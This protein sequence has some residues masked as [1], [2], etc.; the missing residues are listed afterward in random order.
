[1]AVTVDRVV[2]ELEA[3]LGRYEANVSRA[4]AKFDKAMSGIQKS[5]GATERIVSRAAVA[6][7]AA[8]A[9][10]SVIALARGF[11]A[12]ADEAKK[13]DAQLKLATA[14]FGT[15]AQA[16][17]DVQ[18]IADETRSGL[19]DTAGVY[20]NLVRVSKEMGATQ[21]DASRATE[22]IT[23]TF[24][25]SGA[26]AVET[27]QSL[28]QLTQGLQSGTLRGDEFNSV[29]ESA[30]RFARLLAD[31]LG[32]PIG[33]LRK[34]AEE[35]ELT[36]DKL[37]RALTDKKFTD[38]IDA[39]FRQ[40]PITF[41]EAVTRIQNSAITVFGAFDRGGE[42]STMLANFVSGGADGFTDLTDSAEQ[43]G[44][45]IRSTFAGLSDAFQPLLEGALSAF[46]SIE[47]EA[48]SVRQT[49][50]DILGG[51]DDVVN[52]LPRIQNAANSFD[53]RVFGTQFQADAQL[54]NMSGNF[55]KGFDSTQRRLQ[56]NATD[57]RM[58]A[59]LGGFDALGN[60]VAGTP[61]AGRGTSRVSPSDEKKKKTPKSKLNPDA[62][63]REEA[64][65]NDE[66]LHLK[67]DEITNATDR[68]A[69][70][71]QRIA[72]NRAAA[73]T[74]I[75]ND[76]R[77]TAA[78]KAKA[79]ALTETVA[80]LQQAK[81]I[82]ERDVQIAKDA[83]SIRLGGIRNDED[84]LRA[85]A[86]LTDSRTERR[87]IELRLLDLAYQQER[88]ELEAVVASK[89]AT[90]AQKKIAEARLAMLGRVQNTQAA[91]IDRQFESPLDSYARGLRE[92]DTNDRIESYVV[93]EL[94]AVQDGIASA[95]QKAIGTDDPLI[96]GLINLLI[97][98]LVMRPIAEA[99]SSA[100]GGGGG[101]IGGLI[102]G[103]GAIFGFASGGSMTLG[104]RGGTDTNTLS[105]NGSP[106]ANVSR[107]ET[108]NV[109][110]K[111]LRGSSAAG[112][113]PVIVQVDARGAVMNDQFAAQ[114]L[115][116]AKAYSADAGSQA[117]A[118]A[119]RDAP[120]VMAK[121]QRFGS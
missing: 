8:L 54:S 74:D 10:V 62:F 68:A 2:V 89:D 106:I 110:G 92:T 18:R 26:S 53:R 73:L 48:S 41:G 3:R 116:V 69:I 35:G 97:E 83:L 121:R 11:L 25:I 70:E 6:M 43:L 114:I 21:L 15:F 71:L 37:L 91:G 96:S 9:G 118:G 17:K 23:K 20:A 38:G 63:A 46:G 66:I 64:S 107:G 30:P 80:A 56:S 4:E 42:F 29:M 19:S 120:L 87:D 12:I 52:I 94:N 78:E 109:G 5:A 36:A 40:M 86:D 81:V 102:A 82:A 49:I 75:A 44:I 16:Q 31:S 33:Q 105:L 95:L 111:A 117:Y 27:A 55:L 90:E 79:A 13:L 108:L 101:G 115:S 34:M 100:S 76:E 39:E 51:L 104:G 99:L 72:S 45:D 57:R 1:M 84:L 65:L 47:S 59:F 22:T 93:D 85:Q 61:A 7:G 103:V 60:P 112:A 67:A 14:G 28:R 50:A 32:V 77:Y 88:A 113:A 24:K 98:Q 58:Q 119:L